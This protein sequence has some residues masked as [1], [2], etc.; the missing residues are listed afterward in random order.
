MRVHPL[1]EGHAADELP[2]VDVE[3]ILHLRIREC[4]LRATSYELHAPRHTPHVT[5]SSNRLD[6]TQPRT[7]RQRH[8]EHTEHTD[9][10]AQPVNGL[11]G[12][13]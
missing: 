9:R 11:K 8:T 4:E 3:R 13:G 12:K 6:E 2:H 7:Q 10:G 5:A 1:L